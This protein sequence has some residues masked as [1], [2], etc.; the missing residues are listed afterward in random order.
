LEH[1]VTAASLV[2]IDGARPILLEASAGTGKTYQSEGLVVRLVA[3]GTPID[4]VLIITFTKAATAD[5]RARVR[6]RLVQARAALSAGAAPKGDDSI[7]ALF[8]GTAAEVAA[9]QANIDAALRDFDTAAISTI[10]GFCQRMLEQLAFEADQEPGL[11]VLG[12]PKA[13]REQLVADAW[14]WVYA[15]ANP[16]ELPLLG[17]V[18]WTDSNLAA[19]AKAMTG[20]VERAVQPEIESPRG[21]VDVLRAWLSDVDD[22]ADW[23]DGDGEAALASLEDDANSKAKVI[24][25]IAQT[26][27]DKNVGKLR[28]WLAAGGPL[29]D[30]AG[31]DG[32]W[33]LAAFDKKT[34]GVAPAGFAGREVYARFDALRRTQDSIWSEPLVA[35]A[36]RARGVFLGELRRRMLLTYD[37]MLSNLAARIGQEGTDAALAAAIR[38][39]Y[40]AALVDEFQDTDSAQWAILRAV[41]VEAGLPFFA[42]GDPKQSIYSFRG[43]DIDVY[44]EAAARCDVRPLG[45]NQR[46]DRPLVEAMNHVWKRSRPD[47]DPFDVEQIK[48]Q[49]VGARNRSA[50][51]GG[52]PDVADRPRRPLELRWFDGR[53]FGGAP[54][55]L[56]NK[57]P[58]EALVAADCAEQCRALLTSKSARIT[59]G[60]PASPRAARPGDLAVLTRTNDQAVLVR[61]EL[62]ARGIPAVIGGNGSIFQSEAAAWVLAWLDAVADPGNESAARRLATTP[63]FGW[64]GLRLARGLSESGDEEDQVQARK[65]WEALR[66]DLSSCALVWPKQGYFGAFDRVTSGEGA[67]ARVLGSMHG[68]RAATDLR[69]LG[70]LLHGEER[71]SRVGPRGLAEWLRR[72]V[73]EA[74]DKDEEQGRRLESDASAV[75][76]VTIHSAK[77]LQYP[78]AMVP[79]P[80]TSWSPGNTVGPMFYTQR[81]AG[82][83][84]AVD[85]H[86]PG[87]PERDAVRT[88]V[89]QESLREDMRLLYVAM[90]RAKHHVVLWTGAY[91][92]SEVS[93]SGRL[94]FPPGAVVNSVTRDR[95]LD[96]M[97]AHL[98][99]IT[100]RFDALCSDPGAGVGWSSIEPPPS[101]ASRWTPRS[102]QGA[103]RGLALPDAATPWPRTV[104]LG[105]GW[106]V[107][108][109]SSM[110]GG[111]GVDLDDPARRADAPPEDPEDADAPDAG[112]EATMPP[113]RH[114]ADDAALHAPAAAHDLPGGAGTGDWLHSVFEHLS[115]QRTEGGLVA[116]DGRPASELVKTEGQRHGVTEPRWHD[117]VTELLPGWLETPLDGGGS[118]VPA[119]L[120][121]ADLEDADRF[122]E[123]QFDLRLG[124]GSG[125]AGRGGRADPAAA[126]AALEAARQDPAFGGRVWLDSLLK[127][128]NNKGEPLSIVPPIA[129]VLTGFIDLTFRVDGTYWVCDYK[130]NQVLGSEAVRAWARALPAPEEGRPPRLRGLHYTQPLLAW[131]MAHAAYHLQALVYTV[132]LHRLLRQRLP[133][134]RYDAH[135]G[136]HL[137]LFLRGMAGAQTPRPEGGPCLGVWADRWPERTVVGLDCALSGGDVDAVRAAM[138]EVE[139]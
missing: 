11:D 69:H 103:D 112:A 68:E 126:R 56:P 51:A 108:S 49:D 8:E 64:D 10:H 94:L 79:F 131:G 5:L 111:K 76:I 32:T 118:R 46:S 17:D 86:V 134:Y 109:Y 129:G 78:I 89:A 80:W 63:L 60:D 15:K 98:D 28:A 110:S 58:A 9:R 93:P 26:S 38:A 107:A 127:Q 66:K 73:A 137:Y 117:R 30:G 81:I 116:R 96:E 61:D 3:A 53:A 88:Q 125:P 92:G 100:A 45:V 57:G 12:E 133:N 59:D 97:R 43:G 20:P 135:V 33:S 44:L 29:K 21:A 55:D 72:R 136:G 16:R 40:A 132:A 52:L 74:D 6:G 138:Q 101:A 84:P 23:L 91:A 27:L 83:Q 77:G 42:V 104:R 25:G 123:L 122:D 48:Y 82:P 7:A 115:F 105:A 39:R 65:D 14:A 85:L 87:H 90:T 41:F 121:L 50:R 1:A 36:Q 31:L 130:S 106:M 13:L 114:L 75:Q 102:D 99:D 113:W 70:E 47:R 22:F 124:A 139:R 19:L 71:R 95:P 120:R 62:A 34:N 54:T 35:F 67:W 24:G 4:R 128:K 119:G 18:G 37:G 2:P